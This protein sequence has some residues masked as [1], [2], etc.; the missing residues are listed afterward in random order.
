MFS[1]VLVVLGCLDIIPVFLHLKPL[2]DDINNR[3]S[4]EGPPAP[5]YNAHQES[6]NMTNDEP[7]Q[8]HRDTDQLQ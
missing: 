1:L 5:T 8:G 4:Q 7:G 2:V 3:A 6:I